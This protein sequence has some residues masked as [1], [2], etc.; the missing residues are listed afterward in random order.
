MTNDEVRST[1]YGGCQDE[2]GQYRHDSVNQSA[3]KEWIAIAL[4][5]WG[6]S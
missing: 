1:E 3:R 6:M 2:W 5:K 4:A